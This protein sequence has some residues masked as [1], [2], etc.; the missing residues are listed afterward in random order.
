M[1][2]GF[3]TWFE[4]Y[5][6]PTDLRARLKALHILAQRIAL[7]IKSPSHVCA[8]KGQQISD[9]FCVNYEL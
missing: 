1:S 8:L 7:R 9:E 3:F 4:F 6:F 5:F 2:V